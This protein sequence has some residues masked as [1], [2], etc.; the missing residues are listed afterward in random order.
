MYKFFAQLGQQILGTC[1]T[2]HFE[3][4][5]KL[6]SYTYFLHNFENIHTK[7]SNDS[8]KR[9]TC[10]TPQTNETVHITAVA[11]NFQCSLLATNCPIIL[12]VPIQEWSL[13]L[14]SPTQ[15]TP[16]R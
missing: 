1:H 12:N 15:M 16:F 3:N 9:A 5:Y 8:E 14:V 10:Q 4:L 2:V 7:R 13:N 11:F 6:C